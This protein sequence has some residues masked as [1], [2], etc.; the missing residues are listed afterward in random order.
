MS[1]TMLR[2]EFIIKK[3]EKCEFSVQL[4]KLEREQQNKSKVNIKKQD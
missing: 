3:D 1:K 4:K 2:K